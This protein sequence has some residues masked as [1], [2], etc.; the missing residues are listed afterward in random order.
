MSKLQ[1]RMKLLAYCIY[2]G[3]LCV[4]FKIVKARCVQ[5]FRIK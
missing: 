4:V 5:C 2:Y 3:V 1:D